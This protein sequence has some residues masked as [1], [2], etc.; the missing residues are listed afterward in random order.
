MPPA[1][2]R[3]SAAWY[4]LPSTIF[5]VTAVLAAWQAVHEYGTFDDRISSI[6]RDGQG[7]V[8]LEAGTDPGVWAEFRGATTDVIS[9]PPGD[10]EVTGPDGNRVSVKHG[11][12]RQTWSSSSS[13]AIKVVEF[14]AATAGEYHVEVSRPEGPTNWSVGDLDVGATAWHILRWLLLGLPLALASL[15]TIVLMRHGSK[16]RARRE[17]AAGVLASQGAT[18]PQP[19]G[20]FS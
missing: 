15:L 1:R 17:A 8:H 9:A 16:Q 6:G 10:V 14:H 5:L 20:P 19:G 3:P 7:T 2:V 13:A 4:L 11:L 18:T 12:G